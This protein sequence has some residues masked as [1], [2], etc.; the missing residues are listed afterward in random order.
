MR[1]IFVTGTGTEI[2]KTYVCGAI[3]RYFTEK[4]LSLAYYKAALSGADSV[5]NSDAGYV[6]RAGGLDEDDASLLSYL[7]SR[8]LSPHLAARLE[9]RYADLGVILKA[10]RSLAGRYDYVLTEGAG[11]IV[12]P[13]VCEKG[14]RLFYTDI[15]KAMGLPVI[16]AADAG[17]GT[18]N[19]CALTCEY[20]KNR[21]FDVRGIILNRYDEQSLMHRD[22][23]FMVEDITGVKVI[24]T[25]AEGAKIPQLRG[26]GL[27]EYFADVSAC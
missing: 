2:G 24:A 3:A 16:V 9:G 21:G 27:E 7:Y 18:I 5:E 14:R 25:L 19:Y 20:L 22:N 23:L 12:C 15:L 13:V 6:R 11:G 4:K 17:L 10:F 8:P 1:G 26:R